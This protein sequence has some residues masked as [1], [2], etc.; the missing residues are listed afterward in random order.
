MD[1]RPLHRWDLDYRQAMALQAELAPQVVREGDPAGVRLVAGADLAF[2][3]AGAR[4]IAAVVVLSYPELE[5]VESVALTVE[6]SFPYIPGL[7]SFRE[8]PALLAAF[9]RLAQRPD[10]LMADGH[11]YAHPRRFGLACH[12]GLLLDLPVIGVAKSRFIGQHGEVGPDPGDRADLVD[13][14][15]VIGGVLRTRAGSRPLHVSVGHRVSLQA[16]EAWVLRCCRG[17]RL[18]E[19]TRLADRLAREEKARVLAGAVG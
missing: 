14:G 19:P 13:G 4:A 6:Q 3:R 11:G 18:P 16:A 8:T 1:A 15:E 7:L 2:D 9:E 5:P 17:H 12:L 10:L